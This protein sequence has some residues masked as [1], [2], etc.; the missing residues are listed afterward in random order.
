MSGLCLSR[1]VSTIFPQ[2]LEILCVCFFP[3]L[4]A[5]RTPV[6]Q[7][8]EVISKMLSPQQ[9]RKKGSAL[10][11][12]VRARL[13]TAEGSFNALCHGPWIISKALLE[14][15]V[16]V[17]LASLGA[18]SRPWLSSKS[19]CTLNGIAFICCNWKKAELTLQR[20]IAKLLGK[21]V[22]TLIQ[23]E[24]SHFLLLSARY[25]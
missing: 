18:G 7:I 2:I 19:P 22:G 16:I 4:Y 13:D 21:E 6:P 10:L 15:M 24:Q 1:P 5:H 12:R 25:F 17:P 14:L 11:Q 20:F 8:H 23:Q 3:G 9:Q